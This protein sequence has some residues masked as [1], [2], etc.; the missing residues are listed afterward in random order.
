MISSSFDL[1]DLAEAIVKV[2]DWRKLHLPVI[3]MLSGNVANLLVQNGISVAF[4][5]QRLKRM[6]SIKDKL[7]RYSQQVKDYE[8]SRDHN[9]T[10]SVNDITKRRDISYE[11]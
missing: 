1:F 9:V 4:S 6:T 7:A 5:S 8:S 10:H 3:E 2:D 11:R